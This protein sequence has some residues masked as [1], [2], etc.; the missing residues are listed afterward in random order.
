MIKFNSKEYDFIIINELFMQIN[1]YDFN[2]TSIIQRFNITFKIIIKYFC[3]RT[4]NKVNVN[5]IFARVIQFN[6]KKTSL[7]STNITGFNN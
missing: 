3:V 6:F 5:V 7:L 4:F 2:L 1:D